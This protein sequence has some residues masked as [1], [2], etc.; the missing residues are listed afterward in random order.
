[1]AQFQFVMRAGPN[2]G[3]VYPLDGAELT[4]GRDTSNAVSINDA[5]VSRKHAKLE[6]RGTAYLIQDLGSTNGT[7]VNGMRITSAQVLN[8][9]DTVSFGENIMLMYES[10]MDPNA[11]MM[12]S[13][14]QAAKTAAPIHRP[15]P[16]PVAA[17][18]PAPAYSG[19]VPAGPVPVAAP[20]KKKS[21][22]K[23]IILVI[24]VVVVCILLACVASLIW[25]DAD[26]TGG[27]WCTF[28][29]SIIANIMGAG[30]Q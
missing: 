16:A 18:A 28:P 3:K 23:V 27:R 4:V 30:C 21:S 8:P 7:F 19:Q 15:A 13:S 14:A 11:T 12:S 22:A 24:V 20:K 6:L 29:F 26:P 25:V 10:V 5:E 9:G 1:M 17:P 2:V